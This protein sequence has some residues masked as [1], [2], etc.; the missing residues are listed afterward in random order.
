MTVGSIKSGPE[1]AIPSYFISGSYKMLHSNQIF[2]FGLGLPHQYLLPS[3][4]SQ[5]LG[6][7][8]STDESS[9][10]NKPRK[11]N[12]GATQHKKIIHCYKV[13]EAKWFDMN[14]TF[15]GGQRRDSD[16]DE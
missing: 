11:F 10:S 5:A 6:A 4:A 8:G 7:V 2:A 3:Q 14:D 13:S 9:S 1:L 15:F 16:L 12:F